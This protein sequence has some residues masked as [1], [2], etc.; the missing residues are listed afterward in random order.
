MILNFQ[1]IKMK[2]KILRIK[3][4]IVISLFVFMQIIIRSFN[5]IKYEKKHIRILRETSAE[6]AL[7]LNKN[8]EFPINRPCKALLIGSGARNTLKGGLGSGDVESRYYTTCEEGLEKSGFTITSK[9]WL[10]QYPLLKAQKVQEH[11]QFIKNIDQKYKGIDSFRMVSFP[12]VEYDLKLKDTD[13]KADIAIYVL[14]RNSGEGMDRRIIKGD[15]LLTDTEI[16]DILYLNKKYKKFMLVLNVCGVVD[17]S[18]VKEVSNILLLSQLGV[19]TGEILADVILGKQNPSGKLATTWAKIDDYRF[20]NEFGDPQDTNYKE[21]VYIGY[22][23]FNSAGIKPLYPFGF[24]LS[25]TSFDIS[26]VS[27]SNIKDEINIKVKIKNIGK[28][29]GKEVIQ[30]YVSPSQ[31]NEDKPYQS[32]VSFKKTKELKPSEEMEME[33]LFKLRNVA[34]YDI[35]KACYILDKGKYIIRVG[36]S[37]ENTELYGYIELDED[38]IVEQL[39]NIDVGNLGFDDYKIKV[40]FKD[41]LTNIQ[42]IKLTKEDFELKKVDY[43]YNYII[44]DKISKLKDNQLA[45]LCVGDYSDMS[46]KMMGVGGLT[47]KN[48]EEI[49]DF[50]RMADGPAGLRLNKIMKSDDKVSNEYVTALPIETALAQ[51]F[52]TDLLEQ[53][54]SIIGKEMEILNIHLLLAPALNIHRNILCGRNYEYFSEDPLISGKM[55]ASIT[56]GVQSHKNKGATLK[57]LAA[58]NQEKNKYNNNSKMTE[59]TLREIYLKGFQIAIEESKP[60]AIMTSYNLLNGIHP[61]Q[62]KQLLIDILRNEWNFTGLIMTDWSIS[63]NPLSRESI[64]PS[65]NVFDNIKGGNNIMMPGSDIDY[66]ILIEKLKEKSLTRDDLLHCA[67]KVYETVELLNKK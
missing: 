54:G 46:E 36:N 15:I 32:L 37:S 23:Y 45:Y 21:G 50:I 61:S 47:A 24:G 67:S 14:A 18:P 58:N 30:I 34:R 10:D 8:D 13:E 49:G 6:C 39:K 44:N 52:N 38:I 64:Y 53:Y 42:K 20:I 29:S 65:Q 40:I 12:E 63:G 59:R 28:Y 11:L 43:K 55:A 51:T 56:R 22:R 35:K 27:L 17:L 1:K 57:H 26:K 60:T 41:D 62:N 9:E 48:V 7:F 2:K 66:N 33:L 25:Y 19:V 3:V 16:N 4:I 5:N 31:E